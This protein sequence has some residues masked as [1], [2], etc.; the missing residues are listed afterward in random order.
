MKKQLLTFVLT[1]LFLMHGFSGCLEDK[2]NDDN[3]ELNLFI[4]KWKTFIYYF[5][6]NGTRYD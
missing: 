2:Q 4:G 6:E 5:D 3:I 1:I